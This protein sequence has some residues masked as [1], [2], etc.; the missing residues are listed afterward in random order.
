MIGY[1]PGARPVCRSSAST[2]ANV[3]SIASWRMWL[4]S[5][6]T[7]R[8][9]GEGGKGHAEIVGRDRARSERLHGKDAV[10]PHLAALDRV[11]HL[12][13]EEKALEA[14]IGEGQRAAGEGAED[15]DGRC[16]C[17][18]SPGLPEDLRER[19][20]EERDDAARLRTGAG[21]DEIVGAA[22]QLIQVGGEL[23]V[24][25]ALA[26]VRQVGGGLTVQ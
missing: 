4:M 11:H 17:R 15:E 23:R 25:A 10:R 6:S 7:R 21:V 22:E 13:A 16:G 1:S 19:C 8:A 3:S 5:T 26:R 12:A 20:R 18:V 9:E 14:G 24:D 2:I